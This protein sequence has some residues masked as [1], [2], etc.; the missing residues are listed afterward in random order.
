MTLAESYAG[1]DTGYFG[2]AR[3]DILPLIPAPVDRVLELGCGDGTTLAMLKAE[4]RCRSTVGIELF[5]NA[6]Q[7]ARRVVDEVIEGDIETLTTLPLADG[8]ADLILCLD[9]LEHLRDPWDVLRRLVPLLRPGGAVI[10]SIPNVRHLKVIL[11]LALRGRW[12]YHPLGGI[13]DRTHL[14]F[15]TRS[16]AI[17]LFE[18][19]GLHVTQVAPTGGLV[20]GTRPW[21]FD[22]L[23]F[24]AFREFLTKQYLLRGTR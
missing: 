11:P 5:P 6:A 8:S 20:R 24:G 1:K 21:M 19:A 2:N 15:F 22:R 10:A 9:V 17:G 23:T 13:L 18:H 14:R 12:D 3:R 7:L 16:T 4:G